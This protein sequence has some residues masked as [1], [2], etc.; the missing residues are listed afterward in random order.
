M[1]N[2][3]PVPTVPKL[4]P[5]WITQAKTEFD[6]FLQATHFPEPLRNGARGST[7]EYPES[8]IMFIA[9]LSVK[10]KVK[11]YQGI[12]R[13]VVQYWHLLTPD[14]DLPPISESQLRSR[15]KK[16]RHAPRNPAGFISQLFPAAELE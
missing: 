14:P 1:P 8:L 10:V 6:E 2:K 16:I 12:H 3:T 11:T 9:V 5:E 4:N 7:F 13:L 15:L